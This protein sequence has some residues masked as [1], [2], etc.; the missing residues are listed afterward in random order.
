MKPD[1]FSSVSDC[2]V[3]NGAIWGVVFWRRFGGFR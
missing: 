1:D 2:S 3:Q